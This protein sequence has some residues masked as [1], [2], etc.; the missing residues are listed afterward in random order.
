MTR[1]GLGDEWR[2]AADAPSRRIIFAGQPRYNRACF[3]IAGLCLIVA[4]G[5]A[6]GLVLAAKASFVL[7]DWVGQLSKAFFISAAIFFVAGFLFR[8]FPP[9]VWGF[10]AS[11]PSRELRR[12][13]LRTARRWP[14]ISRDIFPHMQVLA[15]HNYFPGLR[16]LWADKG[17]NGTFLLDLGLPPEFVTAGTVAYLEEGAAELVQRHG[18]AAAEPVPVT[19]GN[20]AHVIQCTP[21]DVTVTPR[22]VQLGQP[23]LIIGRSITGEDLLLDP[24]EP[25]H[26][27]FTGRTRSGKSS[28]VYTLLAQLKD[29]PVQLCGIDPTGILFNAIGKNGLGG[30]ALRVLT[31][32]DSVRVLDVMNKLL[33]ELD[34]RIK[35]LLAAGK[36]KLNA[37]DFSPDF[38]LLIVLFEEYPGTLTALQALDQASGAKVAD[39]IE[40]KVKAAV[41]RL[42]LEG[43]K[44]GVRVWMIS[45]R[46]DASLLTGVLRSQLTQRFSFALDDDGLRMIHEGIKPEQIEQADR[47]LPGQGF[48]EMAGQLRLTRFRADFTSY[49]GLAKIYADTRAPNSNAEV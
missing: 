36:D 47:F 45:Q 20:P 12:F 2:G 30:D 22:G 14:K 29:K 38:P 4:S 6:V 43:A 48:I 9:S 7:P 8:L 31:V 37:S 28:L 5:F 10:L 41:Q 27:L 15:G 19:P 33:A 39:R 25:G 46:A 17:T 13:G 35:D 49:E 44:V 26:A 24:F 34:K 16:R 21:L 3:I 42:A 32:S 23:D 18:F 40:T 1:P 11:R